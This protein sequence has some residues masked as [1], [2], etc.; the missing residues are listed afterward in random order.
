MA[1]PQNVTTF[2]FEIMC[3]FFL[4]GLFTLFIVSIHK[5]RIV[6]KFVKVMAN[7]FNEKD[8]KMITKKLFDGFVAQ[9]FKYTW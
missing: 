2:R 5:M 8:K 1:T 7:F 3:E 9:N 4:L 6:F